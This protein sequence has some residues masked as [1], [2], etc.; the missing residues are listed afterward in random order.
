MGVHISL[1]IQLQKRPNV[2]HEGLE[3]SRLARASGQVIPLEGGLLTIGTYV[4]EILVGSRT[5]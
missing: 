3:T 4:A 1:A 2:V 5:N